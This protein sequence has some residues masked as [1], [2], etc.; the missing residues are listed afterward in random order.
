M[1]QNNSNSPFVSEINDTRGNA[2]QN[3]IESHLEVKEP[4]IYQQVLFEEFEMGTSLTQSL[5]Y[6][7]VLQSILN[8]DLSFN[9]YDTSYASHDFHAFPA[10]FPP[11]LPR[12]FILGLTKPG[13]VVLD[14][15]MGSGTTIVEAF[16]TDRKALGFDIDPLARLISGVKTTALEI[17]DVSKRSQLII[18]N[19]TIS[20]RD[21]GLY[22]Q[23]VL[24]TKWDTST[25]AFID[26]WFAPDTQIELIA[27]L[28]EIEQIEDERIKDFF[29]L[30]FSACIITKTG[31]VSLAFDLAHTRPHKAKVAYNVSGNLIYGADYLESPTA[32]TEF[33]TKNLRSPIYE[34]QKRVS[35]NIKSLLEVPSN[36]IAPELALGNAQA[37]PIEKDSVDLV[38]TSPPYASN[39]I[40]YMRAHKFS[41]VW[42]GYSINQL[43][44]TRSYTIGG[45]S[46]ND[47]QFEELPERTN[48]II[49]NI[50]QIDPKKGA[51]LRRY[52]S[53]MSLVLKNVYSVLKPGKAAIL[54]V[55]SSIMRNIDT[56]T[57]TCLAEIGSTLGFEIP[58]I[59]VRHLDRNRR[60]LPTGITLD[61]NSQ[62]QQR[63]HEEFVISFYKPC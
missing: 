43:S 48:E 22:L 54:V 30:A 2:Y 31:G 3:N 13:D 50:K 46:T 58:G 14:P 60:M 4:S 28:L 5:C 63:M 45:E 12:K 39:A 9:G 27:L 35:Q 32:R 16:L 53:E 23:S 25:K 29:K 44:N 1:L 62:I 51:V 21:K 24:D 37:L 57:Q 6:K 15:M 18:K 61:R 11:Q 49:N 10:K 47:F 52:Y 55:A 42:L 36:K 40:D 17:E 59:G 41:L 33:L 38:V 20:V 34:F 56:Q 7:D 8:S 19:A 26:Y